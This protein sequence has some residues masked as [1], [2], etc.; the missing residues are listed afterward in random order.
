MFLG[1]LKVL[2]RFIPLPIDSTISHVEVCPNRKNVPAVK[3]NKKFILKLIEKINE[4][5]NASSKG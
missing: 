5:A 1:A 4:E 2:P 3:D